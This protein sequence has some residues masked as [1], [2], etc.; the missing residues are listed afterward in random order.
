MCTLISA[1]GLHALTISPILVDDILLPSPLQLFF[2]NLVTSACVN[3]P[4]Q[5]D[6]FYED[7]E[8]FTLSLTSPNPRIRI[9]V[10]STVVDITDNDSKCLH[11]I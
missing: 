3:I 9:D 11:Y 2:G 4:T 1:T 8:L 10:S 6:P 7:N 5:N